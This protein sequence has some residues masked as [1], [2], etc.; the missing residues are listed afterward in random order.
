MDPRYFMAYAGRGRADA[1]TGAYDKALA[2]YKQ[3]IRI[4]PNCACAYEYFARLQATCPDKR[5]RD[6]RT[7]VENATKAKDL[8]GGK[9]WGELDTLAA[10]Y[11]ESGNFALAQRWQTK[12]VEMAPS[13]MSITNKRMQELRSRLE[14]YKQGKAYREEPKDE[15][16]KNARDS[17]I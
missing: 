16:A 11:A 9:Y 3:A 7:A 10:A 2:D 12:A 5:Y 8:G 1:L 14:L 13:D 4:N 15:T 6:G 17:L